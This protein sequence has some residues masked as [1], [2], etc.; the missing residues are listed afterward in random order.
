MGT[1]GVSGESDH[2]GNL[3]F[4]DSSQACIQLQVLTTGQQLEDKN[5][6]IALSIRVL[7]QSKELYAKRNSYRC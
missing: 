6:E 4:G 2:L 7:F 1:G 3:G 5:K